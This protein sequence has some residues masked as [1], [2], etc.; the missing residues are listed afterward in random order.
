[1]CCYNLLPGS[2]YRS[3]APQII[4]SSVTPCLTTVVRNSLKREP[5]WEHTRETETRLTS[6]MVRE[7][8][9]C[10]MVIPMRASTSTVCDMEREPTDSKTRPDTPV[11]T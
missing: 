6:D 11:T 2:A 4:Y 10:P 3:R 1:M 8:L 5:T 7:R 9:S